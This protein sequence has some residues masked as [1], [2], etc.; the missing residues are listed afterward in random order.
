MTSPEP[1]K[2]TLEKQLG[3]RTGPLVLAWSEYPVIPGPCCP[4]PAVSGPL[5]RR[6]AVLLPMSCSGLLP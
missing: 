6:P 2:V 3:D 4:M 1:E 5:R